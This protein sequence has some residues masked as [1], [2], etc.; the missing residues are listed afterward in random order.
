MI[1]GTGPGVRGQVQ[2]RNDRSNDSLLI[3]DAHIG[4]KRE[5]MGLGVVYD[6]PSR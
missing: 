6:S 2:L 3:E 1:V 4:K 5:S